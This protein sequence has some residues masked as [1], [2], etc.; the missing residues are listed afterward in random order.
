[1]GRKVHPIGFRLN[2]NQ[3]WMG[4]WYAEGAEYTDQLHQDF[5]IRNLLVGGT[6]KGG[7][8]VNARA[9]EL[10]KELPEMVLNGKAGVSRID[11]ERFP[12]KVPIEI[13]RTPKARPT[14]RQ[15]VNSGMAKEYAVPVFDATGEIRAVL[16]GGRLINRDYTLV[17]RVRDMVF[18][19]GTYKSKPVG[20]VT[21]FQDDVR[22]STNVQD[23]A[24]QRVI[25]TRVSDEVYEAVIRQGRTWHERAF[26]VTDWYK[27]AYEPIR[28][29]HGDIIGILYVGILEQP[30]NDRAREIL[31]LTARLAS[32][33]AAAEQTALRGRQLE[34]RCSGL[35]GELR[36]GSAQLAE[37]K[38]ALERLLSELRAQKRSLEEKLETQKSEIEEIRRRSEIEFRNIASR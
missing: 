17:D 24:G 9:N 20:T 31:D 1:M 11:I 19:K 22:I 26:V 8:A 25:G 27:T 29:I 33:R 38:T 13:K 23:E 18:G 2:I 6:S 35:E 16:Y 7:A 4:R 34:E 15:V 37:E 30:F 12:G 10:R 28:T 5:A 14:D 36:A 21:I 3:P 32:A